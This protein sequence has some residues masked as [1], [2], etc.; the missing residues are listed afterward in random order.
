M[1]KT[2]CSWESWTK[3]MQI[4]YW[5]RRVADCRKPDSIWN[6]HTN[7]S[8]YLARCSDLGYSVVGISISTIGLSNSDD[9][10]SKNVLSCR[11][12][13]TWVPDKWAT[14]LVSSV[15]SIADYISNKGK[16][17]TFR[18]RIIFLTKGNVP[19]LEL[20]R[21]EFSPWP[22]VMICCSV[23]P[24]IGLCQH[25]L[26][27]RVSPSELYFILATW[28]L[29]KYVKYKYNGATFFSI[30][31]VI[32]VWSYWTYSLRLAVCFILA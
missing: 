27:R 2:I 28:S 32:I 21:S 24:C 25:W 15:V 19:L 29:L 5:L 20:S 6:M 7:R 14:V 18:S 26:R 3:S 16:R 31:F 12:R 8:A 4:W 30:I 17:S 13:L 23:Q 10:I 22:N 1:M 11:F 9:I